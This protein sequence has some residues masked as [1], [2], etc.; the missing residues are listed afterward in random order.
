MACPPLNLSECCCSRGFGSKAKLQ[1][2]L[3]TNCTAVRKRK[4]WSKEETDKL[5]MAEGTGDRYEFDG[6]RT[7]TAIRMKLHRI[8]EVATCR[9]CMKGHS[10]N[11]K[12][13]CSR[14]CSYCEQSFTKAE[15]LRRHNDRSHR[16]ANPATWNPA[17]QEK[18]LNTHQENQKLISLVEAKPRLKWRDLQERMG[19]RRSVKSLQ[20]TYW[21][22]RSDPR[23]N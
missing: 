13:E 9:D 8:S 3:Q 15:E 4:P 2:H 10:P 19:N 6:A 5:R 14:K 1:N 7:P 22:I 12:H 23:F 18:G 20:C 11:E 16:E 17:R 21:R